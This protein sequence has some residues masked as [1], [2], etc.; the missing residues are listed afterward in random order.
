MSLLQSMRDKMRMLH[1]SPRTEEAYLAWT[2]R[3]VRHHKLRH[4]RDMG[5]REVVAFLRHLAVDL[6][7][8]AATQSQ[9]LAALLFLYKHVVDLPLSGLG[10]IPRARAPSRLPVVLNEREVRKVL[11]QLKGDPLLTD[12]ALRKRGCDLWSV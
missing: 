12:A 4:P 5:E 2:R 6:K 11:L 3:F 8:A 1:F 10:E 9:A 7:L